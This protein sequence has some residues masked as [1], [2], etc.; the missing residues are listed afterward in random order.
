MRRKASWVEGMGYAKAR[1]KETVFSREEV[2]VMLQVSAGEQEGERK[3]LAG[4]ISG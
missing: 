3:G 2:S 1:R 4:V